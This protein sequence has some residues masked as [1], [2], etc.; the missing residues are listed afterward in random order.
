MD[1]ID[2]GAKW[3][4]SEVVVD[5]GVITSRNPDDSLR[6]HERSSRPWRNVAGTSALRP[7]PGKISPAH[8]NSRASVRLHWQRSGRILYA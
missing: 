1:T 7:E 3:E 2:A 5:G 4:D 8:W 6:F